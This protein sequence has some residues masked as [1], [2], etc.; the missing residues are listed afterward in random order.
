MFHAY[1]LAYQTPCITLL[2]FLLTQMKGCLLVL[3]G[4]IDIDLIFEQ[5]FH[6]LLV[7]Q[8]NGPMQRRPGPFVSRPWIS[9]PLE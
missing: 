8:L 7:P 3:V 4:R 5:Q 2:L 6:N 9:A 1:P